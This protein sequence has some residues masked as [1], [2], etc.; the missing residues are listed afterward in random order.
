MGVRK[1]VRV[2]QVSALVEQAWVNIKNKKNSGRGVG[3]GAPCE[4][5]CWNGA[6]VGKLFVGNEWVRMA[7]TFRLKEWS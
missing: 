6:S 5:I 1:R 7:H 3:A 4:D 2:P